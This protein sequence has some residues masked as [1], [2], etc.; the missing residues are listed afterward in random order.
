MGCLNRQ[1]RKSQPEI[2]KLSEGN[3]SQENYHSTTFPFG[4]QPNTPNVKKMAIRINWSRADNAKWKTLD[5][6]LSFI[7]RTNLKGS[8]GMKLH[9]FTNIVHAACLEHFGSEDQQNYKRIANRR[10][11][12]KGQLRFEQRGLK[13]RLKEIPGD[14]TLIKQQLSKMKGKILIISRAENARKRCLKKRK[15]RRAFDKNP[16]KFTQKLFEEEKNGVLHEPKETLEAH[17][18]RKYFDP[19]AYTPMCDFGE[20]NRP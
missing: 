3:H 1:P 5:E 15:A 13:K 20:L 19:L 6:E 17:P 12:E 11:R 8:I 10:Q 14:K 7:L 4:C 16:F 2:S 9:S 18:Q